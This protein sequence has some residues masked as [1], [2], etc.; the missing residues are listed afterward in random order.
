MVNTTNLNVCVDSDIL[1]LC[2][3]LDVDFNTAINV[4]LYRSLC[5]GGL[6]FDVRLE[7]L[8]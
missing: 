6:L 1:K 2:D 8:Y 4:F 5:E 3:E 7:N